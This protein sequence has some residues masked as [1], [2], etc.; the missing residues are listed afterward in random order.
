MAH[1][2]ALNP[3]DT[4][5]LSDALGDD[6]LYQ[7]GTL[8]DPAPLDDTA[9][10]EDLSA[11]DDALSGDVDPDL[12]AA[13]GAD[14]PDEQTT[15]SVS[16]PNLDFIQAATGSMS[17]AFV[18]S[19]TIQ[20]DYSTSGW[21]QG[22]SGC[23]CPMCGGNSFG[24]GGATAG[25]VAAPAAATTLNTLATYLNERNTG[26]GG[27]DFWDE[28]WGGG[29]D[30]STPFWN[31][32]NAGTNA[33]NGTITFT[34][35][36]NFFDSNGLADAGR[37][38]A[39]RNALDVYEDV[40]G[41]D[42]V[43]VS[44]FNADLAF[45][46]WDSG[47]A[48]ANFDRAG[49]GS[50]SRAWINIATNWSGNGTIGDYY[51]HTALHEIGHTLGLGHQGNY[52]A[53]QG[54]LT[55]GNQAQWQND[56]I[57]Y[58]MMS[59]W[60]QANYTQAGYLTPSGASLGDVNVIGPQIVDWIALDRIYNPQGYGI[61]DGAT[62]GNTTW[63]FNTT[64][65]TSNAPPLEN[66]LNNAFR[67]LSDL[68]DTNTICIVDGGG[69][70]TL[71]LSGF[72]N[73]SIIDLRENSGSSTT[74]YF[75]SV[76]G[77]NGNLSTAVGTVIENAVGGAAGET[78]WG[79]SVANNLNGGAGNDTIYGGGGADTLL[80]GLGHD[81]LYAGGSPGESVNGGDGDDHIYGGLNGQTLEGGAG[82][83][84]IYGDDA[85][86]TSGVADYISGG[87]GNDYVLGANAGD[88]IYGGSGDDSLRGGL[89]N[90]TI[91]GDDGLDTLRGE[92]GDDVLQPNSSLQAGE[93]YDGGAGNDTLDFSNFG[94][95]YA[96]DLAAGTFNVGATSTTLVSIENVNAGSGNDTIQTTANGGE[97]VWGNG[98]NDVIGGGLNNQTLYGGAGNDSIYG[99]G[100]V[101]QGSGVGDL[102]DGGDGN[103]HIE[104]AG[105]SDTMIGGAGNDTLIGDRGTFGAGDSM[106]GGAD[107]DTVSYANSF[108]AVNVTL[109]SAS[110]TGG[111]AQ[112]D[113]LAGFEALIGS[114]FADVLT[115]AAFS[116]DSLYGGAGNDTLYGGS[117]SSNGD[118]LYGDDGND[119][120]IYISGEGYD[121]I[122][123][124]TAADTAILQTFASD[125][126]YINLAAGTF[127]INGGA[128]LRD[129]VSIE[130]VTTGDNNDSVSGTAANN[131]LDLGGGN[132]TG[133]GGAGDDALY[134]GA[135]NDSLNA[136]DGDDVAQG[137]DG[138]D[139]LVGGAGLDLLTGGAGA[140][141]MSGGD[142]ADTLN[143]NDGNDILNGGAGADS[144]SGGAG[145]DIYTVDDAGDVV[146]EVAGQGTADLINSSLTLSLAGG[147]G[148]VEHLTLTGGGN[149]NGTGNTWDN[150]ITGNNGINTLIG[151][152]GNDTLL[153][154]GGNDS[155]DGGQGN[156]SLD[157]GIGN[158]TLLGANGNDILIGGAGDDVLN[159]GADN[160]TVNG[161]DG[162]DN[163]IGST[164]DDSLLGG[165]GLDT[166]NAGDGNDTLS[167]GGDA[168]SLLGGA[169]NDRLDGGFGNDTMDGGLG[170]D[171]FVFAGNF[172][173]DTVNNFSLSELNEA[174]DVSGIGAITDFTDLVTNH[175]SQGGLG[176]VITVGANSITLVGILA[177]NLQLDDFIF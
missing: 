67:S 156:D 90:D 51:F 44:D 32:T 12:M 20:A 175:L 148:Q 73:N 128:P 77:L 144:M 115:G 108:A 13:L 136:G 80:G 165:N 16:G 72:S 125:G 121:N 168:D 27:N 59:Y 46:D 102:L 31:L 52:N 39:I 159:A 120:F 70:D 92:D 109:N 174:I 103:D 170:A 140:D 81:Y 118:Y 26:S 66:T 137:G 141:S 10:S 4:V 151:G 134:G 40:L 130:R 106:D 150:Q 78:I 43:E 171:V 160:D 76:A 89:G 146:T 58:T 167:G 177:A 113:T 3:E 36:N 154:N 93:I 131:R 176:A 42:F 79:N 9:S 86:P 149:I 143:G 60:A 23:S 107:I 123:G 172:G 127:A 87:S 157:G 63:G 173:T 41:I 138:S 152:A 104:G 94:G 64:W 111:T 37:Q 47:R 105:G 19:A 83:D 166:L 139:T 25:D 135:G 38:E 50:I 1:D 49:D 61:D 117:N 100:I 96:V 68:L 116:D 71:D 15:I 133:V 101:A 161:G 33:Q 158:D 34:F 164:G 8:D 55:Y 2:S 147:L 69:I 112:G 155:L 82:N 21:D 24:G 153:G 122:Y 97:Q 7:L 29:S 11:S 129:F 110:N 85:A 88:T 14:S 98:G 119:T 65:G 18:M 22:S 30:V 124:G 17:A 62:T 54:S 162:A 48:Y 142:G 74:V 126:Y 169:G 132:D 28:F 91:Y 114:A 35:G 57:Q 6:L 5:L 163:L 84:T 56:T 53:G 45:G 99:D 145:D 95:S 75:S